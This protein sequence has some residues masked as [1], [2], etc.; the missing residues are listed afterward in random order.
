MT[1]APTILVDPR[2]GSADLKRYLLDL[3]ATVDMATQIP[4]DIAFTGYGPTGLMLVGME[5]KLTATGDIFTSMSDGRLTG[6]QLPALVNNF[7]RR[8]LLVEGPTRMAAGGGLEQSP[9][10]GVWERVWS[11]TARE[12]WSRLDSITEFWGVTV[13]E[14][15]NKMQS[16]AWI[17][18]RARYWAKPYE[19]HSSFRAWDRSSEPRKGAQAG[20]GSGGGSGFVVSEF[21][22]TSALPIVQRMAAQID[23]IGEGHSG[24]VAKAF[25]TPAEMILGTDLAAMLHRDPE[26]ARVFDE[27]WR[28]VEC[29]QK[30]KRPA[31]GGGQYRRIHFSKERV[32]KIRAQLWGIQ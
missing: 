2:Q 6:T 23:G 12:Y 22:P 9:K 19:A 7:E 10:A 31:N 27:A 16:A 11:M 4:A 30:L 28:G 29:L 13:K 18:S 1:D 17:I 5:Y 3:G 32:A 8:Y 15:H 20:G 25:A 21:G 14:T 26:Y 24:Y